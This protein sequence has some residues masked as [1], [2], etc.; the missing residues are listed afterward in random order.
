ME[1]FLRFLYERFDA[2]ADL[3]GERTAYLGPAKPKNDGRPGYWPEKAIQDDLHQ[4]LAGTLTP[5]TVQR[6]IIDV[7]SGRTDV[8]Y[9]PQSGSRFVAEVKRRETRWSRQ[10]VERDYLAQATNYTATGP[11]FGLLLV[12]DHSNHAAGYS[13]IDDRVW[14]ARHA[15]SATEVARLIVVGVLPIGRPT[16]SDL[17]MPRT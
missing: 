15:R 9:T 1:Q 7:A 12:G 4:H 13:S 2:Q 11:P 3:Y 14:I 6:E 16:P 10:A 5:G 8:T 17:R